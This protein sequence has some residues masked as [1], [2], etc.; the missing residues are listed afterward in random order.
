MGVCYSLLINF[1]ERIES[2]WHLGVKLINCP[3]AK[4]LS[5]FI[6][7]I[8]QKAEFKQL[9]SDRVNESSF[10]LIPKFATIC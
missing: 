1:I 10:C 5:T 3:T 8:E 7:K 6:A 2:R 4:T 9:D